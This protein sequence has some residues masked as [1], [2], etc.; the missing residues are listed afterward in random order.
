[1]EYFWLNS[2]D[3]EAGSVVNPGNWSRIISHTP[4]HGWALLEEVYE[5]L[6]RDQFPELPS[7]WNSIFLFN[8]EALAREFRDSQRPTDL[9]YKVEPLDSEIEIKIATLDMSI[10]NPDIP[11]TRPLCVSE[12][13]LQALKYWQTSHNEIQKQLPE[14]LIEGP[15]KVLG[16]LM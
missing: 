7:R 10:I 1:M 14:V 4:G 15:I 8:Q 5:R 11:K 3:I 2:I 12:L 13:E 9:L 6:R 16:K